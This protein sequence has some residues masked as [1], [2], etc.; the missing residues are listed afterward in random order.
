MCESIRLEYLVRVYGYGADEAQRTLRSK[1][2]IV[3]A[4][5]TLEESYQQQQR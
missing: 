2:E 1:G 4:I 5:R 3:D